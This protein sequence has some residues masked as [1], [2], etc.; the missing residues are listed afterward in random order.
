MSRVEH[1]D[2]VILG[3]GQGGKAA[4]PLNTRFVRPT[5]IAYPLSVCAKS[6]RMIIGIE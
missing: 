6:A 3:S 4:A 2:T 5:T 1:V